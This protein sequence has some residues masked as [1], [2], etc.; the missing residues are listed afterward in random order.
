MLWFFCIRC[1]CGSIG[2]N[3]RP[4]EQPNA[5]KIDFKRNMDGK[6]NCFALVDKVD[7]LKNDSVAVNQQYCLWCDQC[8]W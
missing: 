7:S 2:T 1:F 3:K 5:G 4:S 8:P 6:I